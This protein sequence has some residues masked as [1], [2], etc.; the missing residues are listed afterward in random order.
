MQLFDREQYRIGE[1]PSK[2]SDIYSDDNSNDE[3][4]IESPLK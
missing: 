3:E 1:K 4:V 2:F